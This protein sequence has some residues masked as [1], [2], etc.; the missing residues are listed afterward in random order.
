M[1]KKVVA[2]LQKGASKTFTKVIKAVKNQ[3]D[4]YL[5]VDLYIAGCMPR[6]EAIMNSFGEL[7]EMIR[8]GE[9]KGW[10]HY[11]DNYEWYK[12]NQ[13]DSLGEVIIHDEFHE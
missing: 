9:A 8:K 13:I 1:A 7:I 11:E 10:K 3:L 5:P 2:T 6:P 4:K 12:A